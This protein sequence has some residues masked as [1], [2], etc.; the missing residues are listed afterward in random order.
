VH[1]IKAIGGTISEVSE[2]AIAIATAIEQRG[3]A[4]RDQPEHSSGGA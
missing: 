1:A 3:A 4:T 2:V